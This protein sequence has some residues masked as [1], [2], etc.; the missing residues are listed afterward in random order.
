M[1]ENY[2]SIEHSHYKSAHFRHLLVKHEQVME[3]IHE[4]P[5]SV[6][7]EQAGNSYE[8]RTIQLLTLGNGPVKVFLWSQM[9]GDEP[10]A[11]MALFD[12]LNFLTASDGNNT[13]REAILNNCTLFIA[14][15]INPDGAARFTRRN[16]QL[17]DINRD[18][19][20]QQSPE[21]RIL[22]QLRDKINPDFG[23]NLHDQTIQWSAGMTGKPAS[24]SYL[25]P[26]YDE[27]L[28][29]NAVRESA[30]NVIAAINADLQQLVPDHIGRFDDTYEPRAFG[31]NFQAAGTSTILIESGGYPGDFE[32]QAVRKFVFFSILSGLKA[33]ATKS[34]TQNN[35]LDYFAIPENRKKHCSILLKNCRIKNY[36]VDLALLASIKTN[37]QSTAKE[38]IYTIDDLGDLSTLYG[39][40]TLDC[41]A[42]TLILTQEPELDKPADLILLEGTDTILSVENGH[43]TVK[44]F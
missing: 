43:L 14:P 11:T 7:V 40:E 42:Y 16:A 6:R 3:A 44:N 41:N 25:A 4:L 24:L 32:K 1:S 26:A 23:F 30:M 9:H 28:S 12:L 39:Y 34:Y 2:L 37:E 10:T 27:E 17:L 38:L 8:G 5:A 35:V 31:D 18:F 13:L 19:H 29:I 21:G 36:T 22:R 15:M 33:I 20:A